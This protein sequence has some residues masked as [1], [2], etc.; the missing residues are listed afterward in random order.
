MQ[1]PGR[2]SIV[3]AEDNPLILERIVQLLQTR[4]EVVGRAENGRELVK[5]VEMFAPT[6]AVTDVNM[7]D[8]DGIEATRLIKAKHP[9]VHVVVLSADSHPHV[10]SAAFAAGASGFVSKRAAYAEL[11]PVIEDVLTGPS[12]RRF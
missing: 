3:V 9:R 8:L 7:P 2:V 4:F 1:G 12:I 11:I 10:I 6:V 5:H